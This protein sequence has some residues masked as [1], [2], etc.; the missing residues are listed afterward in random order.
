MNLIS[1][2]NHWSSGK[3]VARYTKSLGRFT[4]KTVGMLYNR[5]IV[6]QEW[7]NIRHVNVVYVIADQAEVDVDR[8]NQCYQI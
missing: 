6:Y 5:N 7:I 2:S 8:S 1:R 3:I 4:L